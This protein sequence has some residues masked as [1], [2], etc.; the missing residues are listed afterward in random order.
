MQGESGKDWSVARAFF[1]LARS[2]RHHTHGDTVLLLR[3]GAGLIAGQTRRD[4]TGM[5]MRRMVE[6]VVLKKSKAECGRAV[7]YANV[8]L[9]PGRTR[10]ACLVALAQPGWRVLTFYLSHAHMHGVIR[11]LHEFHQARQK[12]A[13]RSSRAICAADAWRR[14][15]SV[16]QSL[17]LTFIS[18]A[19]RSLRALSQSW[20]HQRQNPHCLPALTNRE[21]RQ[22]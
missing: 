3:H 7:S 6:V 11:S 21:V 19:H 20:S 17:R 13:T 10:L 15:K 18:L 5:A 14:S 9:S 16:S 4:E 12:R 22:H 1:T 8:A 2:G